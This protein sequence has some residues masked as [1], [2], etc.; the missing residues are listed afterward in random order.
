MDYGKLP[1]GI[2]Q[3]MNL[4]PGDVVQLL[5]GPWKVESVSYGPGVIVLETS[6]GDERRVQEADPNMLIRIYVE[7]T[8][9]NEPEKPRG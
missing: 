4:K 9:S 1:N 7:P 2:T 5:D 8:T 3:V 6:R